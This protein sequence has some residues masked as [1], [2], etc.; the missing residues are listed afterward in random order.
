MN[1]LTGATGLLGSHIAEALTARGEHVRAL[2]RPGSDVAFLRQLGVELTE[3]DLLEPA[4]LPKAVGEADIVYHCAARVGN[5]GTKKEFHT[6]IVETTRNLL[7]ACAAGRVGRVLYVSS[8]SVYGHPREPRNGFLT[9]DEPFCQR[10]GIFD[11]YCRAKAE[12]EG[13]ARAYGKDITIV[14]PSWIYGPRDRNGFPRLVHALRDRWVSIV[15]SGDNPLNIVYAA[16]VADG[17]IRAANCPEARGR[18]YHL[19]S[20]GEITQR[21]FFDVLTDA[22]SLPR[23]HKHVPVR[24]AWFGG[25]LGELIARS[26]RWRRSP[27]VTCYGMS[28][29]TRSTKFSIARAKT[30]LGWQP[31]VNPHE[32]L[33]RTL[34][35]YLAKCQS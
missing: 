28:L 20:E 32:G 17:A 16:D 8:L 1:V 2:V 15:G 31:Q 19:S 33:K 14:R 4:S 11:H 26:L 10:L 34:E 13:L 30:E 3:S 6:E 18:V 24:L 9:E 12:A 5:W 21:Q 7:Q 23:I 35:W 27:H 22:L 29:L 25:L